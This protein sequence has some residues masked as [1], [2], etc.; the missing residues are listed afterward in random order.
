MCQKMTV[1]RCVAEIRATV[2]RQCE[3]HGM[4]LIFRTAHKELVPDER[5]LAARVMKITRA[6]R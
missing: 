5:R 2:N 3:R 6:R 1:K 4:S